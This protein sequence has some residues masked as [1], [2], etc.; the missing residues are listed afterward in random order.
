M[1]A[2]AEEREVDL[3]SVF[4]AY[5][6]LEKRGLIVRE[7]G[8]G[9]YVGSNLP[10]RPVPFRRLYGFHENYGED[11]G[12]PTDEFVCFD[13]GPYND[14]PRYFDFLKERIEREPGLILMDENMLPAMAEEGLL[15]PLD[16]LLG[17]SLPESLL[18]EIAPICR[19]VFRY[20]SATYALPLSCL[21]V[22]AFFNRRL[23]DE[24]G[25]ALPG[26][27]WSWKS[28]FRLLNQFTLFSNQGRFERGAMGLLLDPCGCLPIITQFGGEVF[29]RNA[30]CA[31]D[32]DAFSADC[33]FSKKSS[34][35][36]AAVCT[37]G[38]TSGSIWANCLPMG[39]LPLFSGP[40]RMPR[41]P[42]SV[43]RRT[44]FTNCRFPGMPQD[45]KRRFPRWGSVFPPADTILRSCSVFWRNFIRRRIFFRLRRNCE[46]FRC[47][48]GRD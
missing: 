25:I 30:N 18:E 16:S 22:M 24:A 12:C 35:I 32:S 19:Q 39:G 21:P 6:L 9:C 33:A 44:H 42:G 14:Y 43:C 37:N 26:E 31:F 11:L 10:P 23:F 1:R 29:D 8:R 5:R 45:R 20:R 27:D 17:E 36:W 46:V 28:L 7:Q 3:S 48:I 2:L 4:G 41:L 47:W 13:F 15:R 34:A 40:N 38:G